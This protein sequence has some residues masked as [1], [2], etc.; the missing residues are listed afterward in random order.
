MAGP[1]PPVAAVRAAVRAA[2]TGPDA[3]EAGDLVLVACS[4]GPDSI[5]LLLATLFEAPR[6]GLRAGAVTVD[7]G[8]YVGSGERAEAVRQL[9]AGLG[10]SP[11]LAVAAPSART[12]DAARTARYAALDVA[13]DEAR[14]SRVLLGHTLDDQAETVLLGLAR[15]S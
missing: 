9:A 5:A 4:G 15:G 2:L 8:W 12:E 1:P 13:S 14:A 7:H 6:A 11:G 3:P 10:A